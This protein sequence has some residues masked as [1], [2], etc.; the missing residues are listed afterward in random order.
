[1]AAPVAA[2]WAAQQAAAAH[3]AHLVALQAE[4]NAAQQPG[5]PPMD[6]A[7]LIEL[8][9][10]VL[11]AARDAARAAAGVG[12]PLLHGIGDVTLQIGPHLLRI[13][14]SAAHPAVAAAA[15]PFAAQW[16]AQ[17]AAALAARRALLE[18]L[19]QQAPGVPISGPHI[20]ELARIVLHEMRDVA[21]AAAGLHG[22]PQHGHGD[23]WLYFGGILVRI[24]GSAAH[25]AVGAT[26]AAFAAVWAAQ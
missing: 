7:R 22:V 23:V 20:A 25:L 26:A 11:R 6:C 16:A 15:A 13:P 19:F 18:Q 9:C 10:I 17:V 4:F 2:L 21:R 5:G 12:G 1:M 3:A 24:Q 14:G 8:A